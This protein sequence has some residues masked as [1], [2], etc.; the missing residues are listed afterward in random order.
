VLDT[1]AAVISPV[2]HVNPVLVVHVRALTEV[3]QLG[4]LNAA[5]FAVDPVLFASTV[6]AAVWA[7]FVSV[8]PLVA[9]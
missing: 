9:L 2:L 3:L 1:V 7:R 6:F 8:I 4:I 5:T